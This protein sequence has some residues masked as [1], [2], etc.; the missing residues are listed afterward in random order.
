M[1]LV[2]EKNNKLWSVFNRPKLA[3]KSEAIVIN[4][5]ATPTD[6][7]INGTVAAIL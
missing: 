6:I 4:E 7:K 1:I 3:I 2:R 5:R